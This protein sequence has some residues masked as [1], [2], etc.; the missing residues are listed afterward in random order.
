[1]LN[2]KLQLAAL[3]LCIP[4]YAVGQSLE[5]AKGASDSS[6]G[7]RSAQAA[8]PSINGKNV[9]TIPMP[10]RCLKKSDFHKVF[11]KKFTTER[12]A[13]VTDDGKPVQVNF[14]LVRERDSAAIIL[15][16]VTR[17]NVENRY[18]VVDFWPNSS[19]EN[20]GLPDDPI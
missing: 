6:D 7:V 5:T 12:V 9:K 20:I 15:L 10:V 1:M 8:P 16:Y 4:V 14:F 13:V 19:D 3:L 11:G 18:C 17:P 2:S